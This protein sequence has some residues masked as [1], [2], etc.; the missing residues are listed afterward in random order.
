MSSKTRFFKNFGLT[1]YRFGDYESPVLFNNLT[2][3]VDI[4]DQIKDQTSFYNKYTIVSGER[5]DTLSQELYGTTDYYWT[6]YL[7]NDQLR[8]SGWPILDHELDAYAKKAYGRACRGVLG[9]GRPRT[10]LA[11]HASREHS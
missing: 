11:T 6:F 4:I 1:N 8:E 9:E 10:R 7:M 5:P 3:Y 2:Q